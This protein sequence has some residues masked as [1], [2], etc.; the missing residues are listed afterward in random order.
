MDLTK[1][2][3]VLTVLCALTSIG[4]GVRIANELRARGV[5]ANPL[6][7]K[8]MMFHYLREYK[9][10]TVAETGEVGPLYYACSA[11]LVLTLVLAFAM[12][13]TRSL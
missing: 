7:V 13:L 8:W 5:R 6:L 2:F 9:R 12:I 4:F 3:A 1:V 10:V 11:A